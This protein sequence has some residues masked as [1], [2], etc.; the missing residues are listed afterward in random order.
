MD[1]EQQTTAR[2]PIVDERLVIDKSVVETGR[3]RVRTVVDTVQA[4]FQETLNYEQVVVDR[5]EIN[6]DIDAAPQVRQEG[7]LLIIPVVEEYL[8]VEKRLRLKEELHVRTIRGSE[9]VGDTIP[10]RRMRA[11]VE[12]APGGGDAIPTGDDHDPHDHRPLR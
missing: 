8:H 11:V 10:V 5:I 7:D 1:R 4:L 9:P 3:V 2:I 12:R 6:Q